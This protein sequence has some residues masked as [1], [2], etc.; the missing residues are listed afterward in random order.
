MLY[1]VKTMNKKFLT[2]QEK[3][4]LRNLKNRGQKLTKEAKE[5]MFGKSCNSHFNYNTNE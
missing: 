2:Q 3:I 5:N 1:N 4:H